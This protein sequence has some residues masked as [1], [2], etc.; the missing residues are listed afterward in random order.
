MVIVLP[1][2]QHNEDEDYNDVTMMMMMMMMMTNDDD[3]DDDII[4]SPWFR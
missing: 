4:K 1:W 3:D 2:C